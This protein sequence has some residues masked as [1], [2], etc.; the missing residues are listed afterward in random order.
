M[1]K[2]VEVKFETILSSLKNQDSSQMNALHIAH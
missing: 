1:K 2:N